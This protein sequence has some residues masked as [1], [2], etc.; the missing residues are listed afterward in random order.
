MGRFIHKIGFVMSDFFR[1]KSTVLRAFYWSLIALAV[2]AVIATP[3][4]LGIVNPNVRLPD[5]HGPPD[6]LLR[7]YNRAV[8]QLRM[9]EARVN[10][11]AVLY[12]RVSESWPFFTLAEERI[13]Q[14][15]PELGLEVF[16]NL[17]EGDAAD[18]RTNHMFA[19]YLNENFLELLHFG[20]IAATVEPDFADWLME[21]YYFGLRD[22]R[23]GDPGI[24]T[25]TRG[26][27][28]EADVTG[29]TAT[30]RIHNFLP[31]GY[32]DVTRIPF[33]YFNP[34]DDR[35]ELAAFFGSLEGVEYLEIDIRGI[36]S[37][38]GEYFV[39]LILE[40]LITEP[41]GARFYAYH[42]E[43]FL[44]TRTS[45]AFRAWYG[46]GASSESSRAGFERFFAIDLNATPS[47]GGIG[48]DGEITLVVDENNLFGHNL[49]FV[50]LAK[51]AGFNIEYGEAVNVDRLIPDLPFTRLPNSGVVLRFNPLFFTHEDGSAF[52]QVGLR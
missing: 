46:I 30:L 7:E 39:P 41:V 8:Q 19:A 32:E 29:N 2:A 44:A 16:N 1:R 4:I 5:F 36:K 43:G 21:P 10:D 28:I 24:E 26:G 31:Y 13:G 52:E 25:V 6:A 23:F 47:G 35:V 38:F 17:R 15:I 51:N 45:Q 34:E 12:Q 14:E 40:A 37:G 27:N 50:Q 48:F 22:W 33:W 11:F 3:I 20:G 42:N 18:L 49:M 9:E